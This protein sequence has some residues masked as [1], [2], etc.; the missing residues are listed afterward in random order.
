MV[1][2]HELRNS[3]PLDSA[4]QTAHYPASMEEMVLP[5]VHSNVGGG[6]RPGE[7]ARSPHY[8]SQL[9]LIPLR[10]MHERARAAGVPLRAFANLELESKKQDFAIDAEG[11]QRYAALVE[12]YSHYMSAVSWGGKDVGAD[13]LTHKRLYYRWRFYVIRRNQ[14][15]R[16]AG[17]ATPDEAK[18]S[19]NERDYRQEKTRLEKICQGKKK[20][21]DAAAQEQQN[22]ETRL[23]NAY[24]YNSKYGIPLSPGL[25][26]SVQSAR[27]N[28]DQLRDDYLREQA[29]LD[30]LPS[31]GT[32]SN[33]LK[34]YD[35]RLL[36]DAEIIRMKRQANPKLRLR[37]HYQVLLEAYEDEFIHQRGL[38]DAK[39]IHFFDYY[40]H[41][42]LADFATDLSLPSDPRVIYVGKDI[43]LRYAQSDT[44]EQT[45]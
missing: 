39:L 12:H 13:M 17:Q 16:N 14:E 32:L 3:F 19:A 1:A 36:A 23:S 43:K 34:V 21:L 42:S 27:K 15:A 38:R 9:S 44:L 25:E 4:L 24:H 33:H 29:K 11:A 41:D 8:G 22:R 20:A 7:G 5:G 6:Y 40:A 37:P 26:D 28:S 18:L 45:A 2:A 35:E 31:T 10:L 30:T